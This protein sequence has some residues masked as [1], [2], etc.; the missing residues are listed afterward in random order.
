M[1]R[2]RELVFRTWGGTRKGAGR[3]RSGD[4]PRVPHFRRCEFRAEHPLHVTLRVLD[5]VGTL[6][7]RDVLGAVADALRFVGER[8]ALRIIHTSIQ[9]N[10]LHLYCEATSRMGLAEGMRSFKTTVARRINRVLGRSGAVFADR[11]PTK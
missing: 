8:E 5:A 7:V 6:R 1:G 3:K 10:H 4:R 9:N 2:Q 11:Y